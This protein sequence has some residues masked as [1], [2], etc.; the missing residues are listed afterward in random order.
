MRILSSEIFILNSDCY[1]Q[2]TLQREQFL[3]L[4]RERQV[5]SESFDSIPE[6]FSKPRG[7]AKKDHRALSTV[8]LQRH[9]CSLERHLLAGADITHSHPI[10]KNVLTWITLYSWGSR[11]AARPCSTKSCS[12]RRRGWG[13]VDIRWLCLPWRVIG[14]YLE[15]KVGLQKDLLIHLTAP[16]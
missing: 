10:G 8:C 3:C 13:V 9:S 15:I 7:L 4:P 16:S 11:T 2:A 1:C 5:E 12:Y 14:L 6:L